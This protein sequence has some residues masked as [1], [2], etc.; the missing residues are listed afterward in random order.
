VVVF[1]ALGRRVRTLVDGPLAAGRHEIAWD[2]R[3]GRGVDAPA[4]VYLVRAAAATYAP[5][6]KQLVKLR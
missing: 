4:G 3:D 6:V 5:E 1:D 2:G